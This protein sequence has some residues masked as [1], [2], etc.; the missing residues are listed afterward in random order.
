[1]A[2]DTVQRQPGGD[3]RLQQ[4]MCRPQT[5]VIVLERPARAT[6]NTNWFAAEHHDELHSVFERI[7]NGSLPPVAGQ[8]AVSVGWGGMARYGG[9][10]FRVGGRS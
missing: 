3:Q 4:R 8:A 2:S 9:P 5:K 7:I 10:E 1:M 6:G